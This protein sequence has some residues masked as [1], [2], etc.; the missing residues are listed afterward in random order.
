MTQASQFESL[1]LQW[2]SKNSRDLPWNHTTDPY[3]IW[4]SEIILQQTQVKQGLPYFERIS[5][6]FPFLNELAA[7]PLE[8]LLKLWEGLGY[9]SRARNLHRGA[10][11]VMDH[12]SGRLPETR[13]ELLKVPGIGPYTSAAIASFAFSKKEAVVDG[14]VM[15]VMTRVFDL[16]DDIATQRTRKKIEN[17][18]RDQISNGNSQS[19][20]RAIMDLGATV[21]K[22]RNP[23]CVICPLHKI[24]LAKS[25]LTIDERPVNI[26]RIKKR[27]RH[28]CYFIVP[29]QAGNIIIQQRNSPGIWKGLNQL[30]LLEL[31]APP[32]PTQTWDSNSW[33]VPIPSEKITRIELLKQVR[34]QLTHQTLEVYFYQVEL[35]DSTLENVADSLQQVLETKAFPIVIRRFLLEYL[36]TM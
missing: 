28:L 31:E 9:Y 21:C 29:D 4:L 22:P 35:A 30:P 11:Y 26:K 3:K 2:Y 25:R 13:A 16:A 6:A 23:K 36:K 5:Q 19:F 8:D 20:N 27:T 12:H 10:Q 14:N 32:L 7:A 18:A 17:L 33:S 24:C 1:L 34:H 15:R